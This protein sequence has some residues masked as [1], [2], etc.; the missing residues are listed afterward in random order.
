MNKS[1]LERQYHSELLRQS[2]PFNK[3]RDDCL[4]LG[5]DQSKK[6]R[7]LEDN[8]IKVQEIEILRKL[9]PHKNIIEFIKVIEDPEYNDSIFIGEYHKL[10]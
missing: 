4:L 5:V 2:N 6:K 10:N 8:V 1:R 9:P 7:R 3:V